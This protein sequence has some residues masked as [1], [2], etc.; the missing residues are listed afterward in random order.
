MYQLVNAHHV[1]I[2]QV[3]IIENLLSYIWRYLI[4]PTLK[5]KDKDICIK[6]EPHLNAIRQK[7]LSWLSVIPEK[8]KYSFSGLSEKYHSPNLF[9]FWG[10]IVRSSSLVMFFF[11]VTTIWLQ[12]SRKSYKSTI[13][14]ERMSI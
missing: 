8:S 12:R 10:S 3:T 13:K 5:Q 9:S 14:S 2:K 7:L 6:I 11:I 1:C 4:T